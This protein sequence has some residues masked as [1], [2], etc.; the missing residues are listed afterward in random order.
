MRA[1][2]ISLFSIFN[3]FKFNG[4]WAF[5][6][7]TQKTIISAAV[8]LAVSSGVS[9]VLGLFKGRLL[10]TFFGVSDELSLFYTA[11]KIPN[12][13]YSVLVVGAISTVFI[14]VFTEELK[15]NK[16]EA[17]NIASTLISTG[18]MVFLVL[19]LGV[20]FF[21]EPIMRLLAVGK[22]NTDQIALGAHLMRIMIAS[23]LIL[24][25]SS[26]FTSVLQSFRHFLVPAMAPIVYNLGMLG[27][28]YFLS[29]SIGIYGPTIGILIGALLHAAV[30]LPALKNVNFK[31][32]PSFNLLTPRV[33]K[34]FALMPP[35]IASVLFSNIVFTINNSLAILVSAA[36]VVHLKFASTLQFFPVYLFGGSMAAASLPV[37]SE[38]V[39]IHEKEN[40]KKI[41]LTTFHQMMFLVLPA[42]VILLVLRIPVVRLVYGVSNFA[43]E[44]T[45]K[46]SYALA[47]FSISIFAQ[48]AFYLLTRAFYALKDTVT[49]VKVTLVTIF[50]NVALSVLFVRHL[51]LGVWAIAFSYSITSILDALA[52]TYLLDKKLGGFDRNSLL[53]PFL[54]ISYS[55]VFMG[56]SLYIP[57]KLL[58][59][60]VF[61]TT[62]TI[63][64]LMLT[65]V[66]TIAGMTSY[67]LFTKL[68]KVKEIELFYKLLRKLKITKVPDNTYLTDGEELK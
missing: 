25:I 45:I 38:H 20:I 12:L 44:D 55:A 54:K 37:L 18:V 23:Q 7:R 40:F 58:D 8:I 65:I 48:S 3:N 64:L 2:L 21:A 15:K 49:P 35:R 26:F 28:I 17:W 19:G 39:D 27:G 5:L 59:Q 10:T 24:V 53:M 47:F 34:A 36:S 31:Y 11:D 52:L 33:R 68:F 56:L 30:Q 43:W 6:A 32:S 41:F 13:V 57:L 50:I 22:F 29:P 63:N 67:L 60:V 14:P 46:T 4:S 51:N 62:R 61:D 9:A 66:V 1:K 16:A 42:S